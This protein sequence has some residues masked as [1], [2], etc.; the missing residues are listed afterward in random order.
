MR[1]QQLKLL[2]LTRSYMTHPVIQPS[3]RI[4]DWLTDERITAYMKAVHQI[5][6]RQQQFQPGCDHPGAVQNHIQQDGPRYHT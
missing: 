5:T 1:I 4:D 3:Y 6:A 2:A